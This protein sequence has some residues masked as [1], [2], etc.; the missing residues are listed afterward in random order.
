MFKTLYGLG[1]IFYVQINLDVFE[2]KSL[3]RIFFAIYEN[4]FDYIS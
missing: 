2:T 3:N 4:D 1:P